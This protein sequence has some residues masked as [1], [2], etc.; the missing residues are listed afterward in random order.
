[1]I[2]GLISRAAGIKL[3]NHCMVLEYVRNVVSDYRIVL[4][5]K[6]KGDSVDNTR[7]NV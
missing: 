5:I 3:D 2:G 7:T 1:M 6:G 4:R